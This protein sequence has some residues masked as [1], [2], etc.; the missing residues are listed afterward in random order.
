MLL[1]NDVLFSPWWVL[2]FPLWFNLKVNTYQEFYRF[3]INI[4]LQWIVKGYLNIPFVS[5]SN[6]PISHEGRVLSNT[7]PFPDSD[8]SQPN[9]WL[10]YFTSSENKHAL[11]LFTSLLNVICAYDPQGYGLP[12]QHVM[13]S[14][15]REQ[16]VEVSHLVGKIPTCCQGCYHG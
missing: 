2:F 6:P 1:W 7:L 3:P 15:F 10:S 13:F 12:Y 8:S 16:L 11:P 4:T 9:L 14:D 5:F